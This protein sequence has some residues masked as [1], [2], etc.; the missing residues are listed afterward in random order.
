VAVGLSI[1]NTILQQKGLEFV[2]MLNIE[3]Q[4]KCTNAHLQPMDT[5]IIH[6]FKAKYKQEF[7]KHL[8]SNN[9]EETHDKETNEEIDKEI[10]NLLDNLP[11]KNC[12]QMYFKLI[13][14]DISTEENLTEEQIVNLIQSEENEESESDSDDD[15]IFPVSVKDAISGLETFIKYFE[16]QNNNFEFNIDNLRIFRKYLRNSRVIEFNSK[17]QKSI[18]IFIDI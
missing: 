1:S 5:G 17:K 13:D 8:E 7:C 14:F 10:I 15:K 16:Q 3:N 18:D 6:S 9:E 2:K 12:V 11:E 4:L